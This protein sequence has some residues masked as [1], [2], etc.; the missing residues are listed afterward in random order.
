VIPV[1][2]QISSDLIRHGINALLTRDGS[3][4][5][6][7]EFEDQANLHIWELEPRVSKRRIPENLLLVIREAQDVV[8][9]RRS[10]QS[11]IRGLVTIHCSEKEILHAARTVAQGERFFCSKVLDALVDT[12]ENPASLISDREKQVLDL[13]AKGKT[14]SEIAVNLSISVHTVNSHRKN[15]L[16]KLNLKSPVQL[17]TFAIEQQIITPE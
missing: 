9:I 2:L 5:N 12:P 14:T 6:V 10:I 1:N 7:T 3:E 13:I 8:S 17:V 11:G 16:K 15:M 4:F